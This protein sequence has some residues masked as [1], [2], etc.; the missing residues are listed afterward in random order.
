MKKIIIDFYKNTIIIY[1]NTENGIN[2][3]K[4]IS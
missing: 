4:S 3:K 1:E 2:T